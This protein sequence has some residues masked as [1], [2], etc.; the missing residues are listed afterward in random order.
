MKR[1]ILLGG[2]HAHVRVLTDLADRPLDG[3]EVQLVT[4]FRRQIYS[5][6][7]P[8]W[9]AGHYP[10]ESC[11]IA[12][13]TLAGR[14]SV[15]FHETAGTALDADGSRLECADG[16]TRSFALLSV[17]TGPAPEL[18][19]LPGAAEH[20]LPIRPIE[21]FVAAW[22][23][24]VDRILGRCHRFELV[25]LGAGAGGVELACAIAHRAARDGWSHLRVAL[26]GSD[27]LPLDGAPAAARRRALK[28]LRQRGIAWHGSSRATHIEANRMVRERAA[29]IPFDACLL[30]TGAAA[31]GW[32]A[33]SGIA[34][35]DGGFIR[36]GPT[37][38]SVSHPNI[39]AAG[40][41][42][43]HAAAPPKS[44]V[45]AVRAGPVLSDNIRAAATGAAPRPW[46]PQRRALYLVSM[47][48]HHAMAMWGRWS[49]SGRWVWY[50]K[51]R[52]DRG[53]ISRFR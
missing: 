9:I 41:I 50:W 18:D 43:S 14:A 33:A 40:D 35:D 53:F 3:W 2:G 39:F 23:A 49:W 11:A 20:A 16:V 7:L 8:G 37:L 12:L 36:I 1:L 28:L 52:I 27:D 6:M 45:Y 4:P 21:G 19:Q 47:G 29:P 42:A 22:P 38:Q 32:P 46:R 34:T 10:I 13:D 24:L 44:G 25:V 17:D 51:D 30:V 15:A 26:V 48:N 31:P 5:G